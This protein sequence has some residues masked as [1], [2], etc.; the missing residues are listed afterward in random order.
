MAGKS[1]STL[2]NI[3]GLLAS[4]VA[5]AILVGGYILIVDKKPIRSDYVF[6]FTI[7]NVAL[8][9]GVAVAWYYRDVREININ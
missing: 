2:G 9:T 4:L 3:V 8:L 7:L 5:F 6:Y 1:V